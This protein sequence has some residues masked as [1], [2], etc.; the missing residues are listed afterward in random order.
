ML[1]KDVARE[2]GAG[3]VPEAWAAAVGGAGVGERLETGHVNSAG[4]DSEQWV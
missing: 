3:V 2:A 1:E 4:Q